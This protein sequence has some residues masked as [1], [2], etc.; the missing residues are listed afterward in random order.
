M[1]GACFPPAAPGAGPAGLLSVAMVWDTDPK[2]DTRHHAGP[3][4]M[5]APPGH[6]V[7]SS[8]RWVSAPD[9][10]LGAATQSTVSGIADAQNGEIWLLSPTPMISSAAAH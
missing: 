9:P 5:T 2:S 7:W 4:S 8:L 1:F 10:P 3:P 6:R